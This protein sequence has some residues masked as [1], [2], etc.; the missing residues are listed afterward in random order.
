MSTP[1]RRRMPIPATWKPLPEVTMTLL[2]LFSVS[3]TGSESPS[4]AGV[5]VAGGCPSSSA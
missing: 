2:P 1:A 5:S 3:A 4:W